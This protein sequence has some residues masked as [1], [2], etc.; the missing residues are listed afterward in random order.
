MFTSRVFIILQVLVFTIAS[1]LGTAHAAVISNGDHF[2]QTAHQQQLA[3]VESLFASEAVQQH[4]VALGVSPQ[5]AMARVEALSP[6]ELSMLAQNMDELPAGGILG[7]LG[8]VFVVL[9][10]LELLDVTNVFSGL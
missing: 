1:T 10:V 6:A 9:I 4:M 5:D 2:V 8:A 7:V 3:R